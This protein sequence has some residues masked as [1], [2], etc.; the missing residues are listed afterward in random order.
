MLPL[1]NLCRV[2]NFQICSMWLNSRWGALIKVSPVD[3]RSLPLD[4]R[5]TLRLNLAHAARKSCTWT[6]RAVPGAPHIAEALRNSLQALVLLLLDLHQ[7]F[8]KG[9]GWHGHTVHRVLMGHS[10]RQACRGIERA[11]PSTEARAPHRG[12][13]IPLQA[14]LVCWII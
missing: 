5:L 13:F 8:L 1:R 6:F 14:G 11:F 9:S 12:V 4:I 3:L 10:I 2:H 7:G